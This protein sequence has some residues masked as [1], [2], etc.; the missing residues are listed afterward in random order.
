MKNHYLQSLL[1]E[2]EK[3]ILSTHQHWF[4]L[5][6]SILFKIIVTIIIAAAVTVVWLFLLSK[7]P[8]AVLGYLILLIPLVSLL[9]DFLLWINQDYIVTNMR[10]IQLSGIVN[11]NVT[12]SSLEKVNDVK[13]SQSFWGRIF[14]FGDVE[15]LTGSELGVNLFK[16]IGNPVR[17]K[18]SML[19][20]KEKLEGRF[21]QPDI[22]ASPDVPALIEK[23][24]KLRQQGIISESEFQNK[25][26]DLLRKM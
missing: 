17:F 5:F 19:N 2:Q 16:T 6:K 3:I 22:V 11:K 14:D 20:A 25:K 18:T 7:N 24:D 4:V 15:I 21:V 23:L 10:V 13:M 12:D 26:S 8:L 1:G 9:H